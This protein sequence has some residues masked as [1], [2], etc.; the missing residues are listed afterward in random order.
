MLEII[1]EA[2]NAYEHG[3]AY[4][5]NPPLEIAKFEEFRKK[6]EVEYR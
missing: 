3:H 6:V 4:E 1:S 5:S 2:E